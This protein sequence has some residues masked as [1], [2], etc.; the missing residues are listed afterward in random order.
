[1]VSKKNI[2]IGFFLQFISLTAFAW[3][4]FGEP[5]TRD[6]KPLE[7]FY[8]EKLGGYNQK[9][10]CRW[11]AIHLSGESLQYSPSNYHQCIDIVTKGKGMYGEKDRWKKN[12]E[13]SLQA[14][15]QVRG[16]TKSEDSDF[17]LKLKT[18]LGARVCG[19][20]LQRDYYNKQKLNSVGERLKVYEN[21]LR[22]LAK[23]ETFYSEWANSAGFTLPKE[24]ECVQPC[25]GKSLEAQKCCYS[26]KQFTISDGMSRDLIGSCQCT[27]G[28]MQSDIAKTFLK[29]I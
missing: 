27:S 29:C 24:K 14:A 20:M 18:S 28:S 11:S 6:L 7:K 17:L 8:V 23:A 4:F 13:S 25:D 19:N 26:D 21:A 5:P 1:M 22:D 3:T 2:I 12:F 16:E 9:S 10:F 15:I